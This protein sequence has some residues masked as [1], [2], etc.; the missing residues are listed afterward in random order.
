MLASS[1]KK[2]LT[3]VDKMKY[4]TLFEEIEEMLLKEKIILPETN[5]SNR[6]KSIILASYNMGKSLST[7]KDNVFPNTIKED[8]LRFL[9]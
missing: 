7:I 2:K 1:F 4:K 6:S 9:E 3:G 5:W 8:G